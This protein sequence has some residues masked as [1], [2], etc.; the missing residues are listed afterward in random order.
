MHLPCLR[1]RLWAEM[2]P[3]DFVFATFPCA[4]DKKKAYLDVN[5]DRPPFHRASRS[6]FL[7]VRHPHPVSARALTRQGKP[8]SSR[9]RSHSDDFERESR[10]DASPIISS[11]ASHVLNLAAGESLCAR[12]AVRRNP[13]LDAFSA[14]SGLGRMMVTNHL[15]HLA[16]CATGG[17]AGARETHINI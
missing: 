6:W 9:V 12:A 15:S 5:P 7:C 16:N 8:Q 11:H 17:Q 10:D 1:S 14:R 4:G 13:R 2:Q 3:F